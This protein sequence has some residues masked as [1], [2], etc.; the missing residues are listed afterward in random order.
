VY[1][2]SND[3]EKSLSYF[4]K[5]VL[6]SPTFNRYND[7]GAA[8][9][10]FELYEE[11]I[12]NLKKALEINPNIPEAYYNLGNIYAQKKNDQLKAIEFYQKAVA[13]KPGHMLT[14]FNLGNA[15]LNSQQVE[16]ALLEFQE[17]SRLKPDY[18]PSQMN[19]GLSQLR[20]GK[21]SQAKSTYEVALL[22]QPD[23]PA[24]HKNLGLIYSGKNETLDKAIYHLQEYLRL[25]PSQPDAAQIQT[26]IEALRRQ[27]QK[28]G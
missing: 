14:H 6:I 20:L 7:L 22:K 9:A 18:M 15:L 24:I 16:L 12:L 1:M 8:C 28:T 4:R 21:M 26:R 17:A 23:N 25:A 5:A 13:L 2:Y 10:H 11:A 3:K 19:L 27:S